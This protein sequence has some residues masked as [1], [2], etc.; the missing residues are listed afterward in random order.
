MFELILP[1]TNLED[2]PIR[3]EFLAMLGA[4]Y[5][6]KKN[7]IDFG[8]ALWGDREGRSYGDPGILPFFSYSLNLK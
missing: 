1:F 4:A 3:D 8:L 5:T 6:F 7:R 2:D